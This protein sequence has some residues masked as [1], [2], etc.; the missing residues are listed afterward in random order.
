MSILQISF[1]ISFEGLRDSEQKIF[2]D[3][4]CFFKCRDRDYVAKILE[5]CGFSPVIGIEVLIEKSRLT[6]DGR[7]KLQMHDLLQE[8]GQLIVTRQFPEEPGKRSRIWRE[9]EVPLS[10]EHLSGLVQLTLK[11][12]K[13]LSS[14]P[15][16]ISSLKSLRTLELSGCSKLKN[17]KALSF[18]GC[19]GPPSSASCY[20]LFPI[21]LML[22]S[23][24][25]GA[26]MLPSL[27]GLDS[28]IKLDLSDWSGGRS[29]PE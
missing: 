21:N 13:N 5:G 20:L 6:V 25:L 17:L 27:S 28:L 3:V 18:R 26:L 14:L 8:L 22:R 16:T 29:N 2:F 7:N 9:E 1:Q 10:I 19:N 4:A 23:S 11:G 15:A 24:D 12:C